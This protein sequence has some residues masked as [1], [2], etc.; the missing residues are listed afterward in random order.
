M[1]QDPSRFTESTAARGLVSGSTQR[2]AL[3]GLPFLRRV[4]PEGPKD[5]PTDRRCADEAGPSFHMVRPLD[6][7]EF[8]RLLVALLP[9][10]DRCAWLEV[11]S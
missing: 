3:S 9:A 2:L 4:E 10:P 5:Y 11:C 8:I 1:W 7:A 6:P